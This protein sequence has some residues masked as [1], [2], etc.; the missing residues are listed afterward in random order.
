[1]KTPVLQYYWCKTCHL[2]FKD[3]QGAIN[4][5]TNTTHALIKEYFPTRHYNSFPPME[6]KIDYKPPEIT[7]GPPIGISSE[8]SLMMRKLHYKCLTCGLSFNNFSTAQEHRINS[9]HKIVEETYQLSTD[10]WSSYKNLQDIIGSNIDYDAFCQRM[11]ENIP[12][13][14]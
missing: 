14:E 7:Y 5:M 4:H 13:E 3:Y 6:M 8:Q 10:F 12:G 11:T 9:W 1:M 2:S